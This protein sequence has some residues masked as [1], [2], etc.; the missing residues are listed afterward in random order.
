MNAALNAI[1]NAT[2]NVIRKSLLA[3]VFFAISLSASPAQAAASS[4]VAAGRTEC[5]L[6][7]GLCVSVP[8]SWERL[9]NVFQDFGFV[10]AEP[11]PGVDSATWPQLTVAAMTPPAPGNGGAAPSLDSLFDLVLTPDADFPSIETQ[12]RTRLLL[13]GASAEIVRVQLYDEAGHAGP[14]EDV[15]LIEGDEGRVYSIALRCDPQDFARLEPVFQQTAQSWR[16]QPPAPAAA[17][18]AQPKPDSGKP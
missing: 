11:H 4:S 10:A 14:I 9:G 1:L 17:P 3:T 8:A 12:Q 16:L 7:V 15:A 18:P 2:R 5:V 13:N 6:S